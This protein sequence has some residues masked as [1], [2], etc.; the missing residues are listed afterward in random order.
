MDKIYVTVLLYPRISVMKLPV[1]YITCTT[2]MACYI[3][4]SCL[5]IAEDWLCRGIQVRL[6]CCGASIVILQNTWTPLQ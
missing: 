5:T 4:S 1:H 3:Y 2:A 6:N